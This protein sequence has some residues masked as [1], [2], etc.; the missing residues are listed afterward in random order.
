MLHHVV[1]ITLKDG[2][3]DEQVD[4][5]IEGLRELPALIPEIRSYEVGRDL[6]LSEANADL[7]LVGSFDSVEDY[8]TYLSHPAHVAVA[9]DRLGSFVESISSIQLSS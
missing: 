6:G 2:V 8:Q 5:A 4:A 3:T 1:L 9:R 7:G